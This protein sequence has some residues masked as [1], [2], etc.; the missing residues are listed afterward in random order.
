MDLRTAFRNLVADFC[1]E[2]K[3]KPQQFAR[4][5]QVERGDTGV[6]WY[7]VSQ[8]D[9]VRTVGASGIV[10]RALPSFQALVEVILGR[11]AETATMWRFASDEPASAKPFR[12][13][14]ATMAVL[15]RYF[16]VPTRPN[17]AKPSLRTSGGS[18]RPKL[19]QGRATTLLP[20]T[21]IKVSEPLELDSRRPFRGPS[22]TMSSADGPAVSPV[23]LL[24]I[25]CTSRQRLRFST[26]LTTTAPSSS[27]RWT[28]K[29]IGRWLH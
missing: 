22:P 11:P 15:R 5:I 25:D 23:C 3:N 4:K 27:A 21:A 1:A 10:I 19:R 18:P 16:E 24:A 9:A 13:E 29:R 17:S 7:E 8:V 26:P 20:L 12:I 28:H 6:T 2:A 14:M